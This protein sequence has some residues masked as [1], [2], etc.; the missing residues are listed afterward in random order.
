MRDGIYAVGLG[1]ALGLGVIEDVFGST[2]DAQEPP[3]CVCPPPPPCASVLTPE[4][5]EKAW[6]AQEAI[7]AAEAK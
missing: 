1:I 5:Q 4:Q 3:A 7:K 6:K 2:A